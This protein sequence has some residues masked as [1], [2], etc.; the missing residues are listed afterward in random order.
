MKIDCHTHI[1]VDFLFYYQGWS[2]YC[3]DIP[4]LIREATGTGIDVFLVFPFIAYADLDQQALRS[5]RIELSSPTAVPYGFENRRLCDELQRCP[6]A[7]KERLWPLLIADPARRQREQVGE[8]AKLP[9]EYRVR[10][11][12]IQG[13]IIQSK[14]IRLL[15]EGRCI[16]D[17]AEEHDLPLLIHSSIRPDDEWSQCADLLRV[18]ESRPGVRFVLAHSCRYHLPS[19]NRV[20]ELPNT[21]FDC[22][23]HVI[24][25]NCAVQDHPAVAVPKERFPSDYTSP[26]TVLRDLAEA[27]PEKLIWG[28]DAP[29]YSIEY[30]HVKMRSSYQREVDCLDALPEAMRDRV[31]RENTLAWLGKSRTT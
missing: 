5:K 31:C 19:L 1:G 4:R 20:A 26:E 11:I 10:G 9:S 8:W 23:A 15:D 12:K 21:W 2:P 27:F 18:A 14:V 17:Y 13:T 28:S 7:W 30:E 29:F 22:S 24:H 3:L 16:L 6:A 25:C